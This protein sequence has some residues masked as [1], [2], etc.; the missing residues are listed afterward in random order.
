[1]AKRTRATER[2]NSQT[3][4][5]PPTYTFRIGKELGEEDDPR[6]LGLVTRTRTPH[7]PRT[8]AFSS[9]Q[10]RIMKLLATV[11][12]LTVT[13]TVAQRANIVLPAMGSDVQAGPNV[14]IAIARPVCYCC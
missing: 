1:M 4:T 6:E 14:I 2:T 7:A 9:L 8:S 5:F 3:T 11:L 12:S 10:L 13:S